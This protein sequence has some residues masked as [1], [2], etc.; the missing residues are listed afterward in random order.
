MKENNYNNLWLAFVN[1]KA[2]KGFVFKDLIDFEDTEEKIN[3]KGAWANIIIK[4]KNIKEAL[5][6]IPLGLD[7]LN[8]EVIFID[9]IE[10]IGSLIEYKEISNDDVKSEA[11]WLLKSNFVFKISDRLFPYK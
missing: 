5:D 7:E 11:D 2:K 9:K 4:S 8:F 1:L 6:I 3:Y 10:N